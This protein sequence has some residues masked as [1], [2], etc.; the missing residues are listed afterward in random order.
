MAYRTRHYNIGK[1]GRIP[2]GR[3]CAG[4]R[5]GPSRLGKVALWRKSTGGLFPSLGQ[6]VVQLISGYE[7]I[8]Y[9]LRKTFA[10]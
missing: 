9:D 6:G 4:T 3:K 5:N 10:F 7:R 2:Q 1:A 8:K